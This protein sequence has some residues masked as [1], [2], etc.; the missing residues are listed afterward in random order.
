MRMTPALYRSDT[1]SVTAISDGGGFGADTH[2]DVERFRD[3][4]RNAPAQAVAAVAAGGS[5]ALPNTAAGAAWTVIPVLLAGLA[6]V[7]VRRRRGRAG[8]GPRR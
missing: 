5:A 2:L 1:E 8:G 6:A 4:C 7:R 3:P